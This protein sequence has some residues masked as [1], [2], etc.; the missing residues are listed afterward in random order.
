MKIHI[1]MKGSRPIIAFTKKRDAKRYIDIV[2][3]IDPPVPGGP[4]D[5]LRT[6]EID[7]RKK[8]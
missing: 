5:Y 7:L 4:P 2:E 8:L 3:D 1:A 6:I